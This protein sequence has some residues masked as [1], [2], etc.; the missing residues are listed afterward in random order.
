[1]S[2]S[3]GYAEILLCMAY[4][5]ANFM[6]HYRRILSD[7]RQAWTL[8]GGGLS[9]SGPFSPFRSL[10][11]ITLSMN[12]GILP[13]GCPA[14]SASLRS[15]GMYSAGQFTQYLSDVRNCRYA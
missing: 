8:D 13:L 12:C 11:Q 1:M 3:D 6:P 2:G 7:R 5:E 4:E 9:S 10:T 15:S 14:G